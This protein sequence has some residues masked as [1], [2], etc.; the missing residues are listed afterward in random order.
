[1]TASASERWARHFLKCDECY[2]APS[3]EAQD[4]DRLCDVG[5]ELRDLSVRDA[6]GI[7]RSL[8]PAEIDRRVAAS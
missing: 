7:L 1:M 8:T 4:Q 6:F 2:L 3:I 5:R